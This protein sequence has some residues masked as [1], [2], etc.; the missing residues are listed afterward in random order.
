MITG[1]AVFRLSQRPPTP[2]RFLGEQLMEHLARMKQRGEASVAEP[3]KGITA[4]GTVVPGLF[5]I[6]STGVPTQS[7]KEAADAFL[8]ALGSEEQAEALFPVNSDAW[9]RWCNVHPFLMRHGVS[10]DGMSEP[11]RQRALGLADRRPS[12]DRQL[13]RPRRSGRDD[14]ALH[15][16]RAGRGRKR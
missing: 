4:D 14:S 16:L 5:P 13:L 12:P 8:A 2:A 3:F 1:L 6:R 11:Q 10:L 7:I 9:R 15:G